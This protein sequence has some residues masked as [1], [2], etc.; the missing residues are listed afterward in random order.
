MLLVGSIRRHLRIAAP[1]DVVW[2]VVRAP[3][4]LAEWFPVSECTM[5]DGADPPVRVVS[6]PSGLRFREEIVTV[7]DDLRRFQYRITGNPLITFHLATVDV[8]DDGDGS[9]VVYS[10]DAT[11]DVFALTIGGATGT[12]LDRLRA[13]AE[14]TS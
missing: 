2:Q 13:L 14:G 9:L 6:V 10:T 5:E 12:A 4:R 3:E 8:I 7:D 11:P 1:P